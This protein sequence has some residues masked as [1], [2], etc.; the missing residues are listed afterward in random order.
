[1]ECYDFE[2]NISAYID[3]EIKQAIYNDFIKHKDNCYN[4][5]KKL[6]DISSLMKIMPQMSTISTSKD[7]ISNLNNKVYEINNKQRRI[8]TKIFKAWKIDS[9]PSLGMGVATILVFISGYLLINQDTPPN[10]KNK[11]LFKKQQ[12]TNQKQN[13]LFN[14]R[15]D[16]RSLADLD[17]SRQIEDNNEKLDRHKIHLVGGKK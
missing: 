4:C 1:M 15:V 10:I 5:S 8:Y 3:G 16:N 9:I 11:N 17:S 12:Y 2:L 13:S 7:F 14:S 6:V